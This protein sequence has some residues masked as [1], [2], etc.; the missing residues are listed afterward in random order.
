MQV[1]RRPVGQ[2]ARFAAQ[3]ADA[4]VDAACAGLRGLSD[5]P[6]TA[7]DVALFEPGRRE[8]QGQALPGQALRG[9]LVL[10]M[11]AAYAHRQFARRDQ[12]AV[13]HVD[14]A[15]DRRAGDHGADASQ[16]EAAV[17]RQ[18]ET[19]LVARLHLLALRLQQVSLQF[20]HALTGGVGD[21]KHGCV[22]QAGVVQQCCDLGLG[23]GHAGRCHQVALGQHHGA[24][25]QAQQVQDGQ[26]FPR[27][28][29]RAIVGR[30]HEKNMVYAGRA[31]QHVAHQALMAGHVHEAEHAAICQ[32]L[33]RKA[34]VDGDASGLFFLEAVGIDAGQCLDQRCLSV[35]DVTCSANDH[36]G[37]PGQVL[38]T[39]C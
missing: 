28:R 32:G 17:N 12:H 20:C 25:R 8:V 35:V 9:L 13:A 36:R 15:G 26:V 18:A 24:A 23:L 10:R 4:R 19:A 27:L 31:G 29:H 14:L 39:L 3:E 30:D 7:G 21:G 34:Q 33:V 22:G 11:Q 38:D 1:H 5:D 6:V 37:K 2:I 16:A